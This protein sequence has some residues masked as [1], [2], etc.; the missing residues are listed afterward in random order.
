MLLIYDNISLYNPISVLPTT[1]S[2]GKRIY[3]GLLAKGIDFSVRLSFTKAEV[4]WAQRSGLDLACCQGFEKVARKIYLRS[5]FQCMLY[6]CAVYFDVD[7]TIQNDVINSY[8][9]ILLK[10]IVR[11]IRLFCKNS[12]AG[13][14]K[15]KPLKNINI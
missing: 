6:G 7:S 8:N 11:T 1:G 9:S 3:T 13:N 10:Q 2:D 4:S 5:H 14:K 12:T 15:F